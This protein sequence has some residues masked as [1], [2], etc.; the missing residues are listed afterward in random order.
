MK[1]L[2][3]IFFGV[4]SYAEMKKRGFSMAL[5]VPAI[6]WSEYMIMGATA[7][8]VAILKAWGLAELSIFFIIWIGNLIISASIVK[9]NDS[10]EVDVTLMESLRRLVDAAFQRSKFA[11]V[12]IEILVLIRLIIWDG[13]PYFII[14]FRKRLEKKSTQLML[15]ITV[16]F[17]QMAVWTLLYSRGYDGFSD[18]LK[19]KF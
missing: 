12:V 16:S 17:V 7:T 14:F 18:L 3:K 1:A 11:G 5:I 4:D 9:F 19:T 10:T 6:R 13:A 15:F 8:L 2:A